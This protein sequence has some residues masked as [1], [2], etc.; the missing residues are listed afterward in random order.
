MM[1][2]TDQ[3][4]GVALVLALFLMSAM[5]VLAASLMFLSQ[6]ETYAT[7]NYRMMSQARYAAESGIQKAANFLVDSAQYAVPG[8]VADP[9]NNY[10]TTGSP[11]TYNSQTVKLSAVDVAASNY[12]VTAVKTAF[13]NAARGSLRAGNASISYN[14]VATLI[15]MQKFDAYGGG[16]SVVQTWQITG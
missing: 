16:V 2:Q 15:S 14:A 11:V 6:T 12:P 8:S 7:M 3:E 13:Y 4:R 10:V 1:T 5:S 9:L